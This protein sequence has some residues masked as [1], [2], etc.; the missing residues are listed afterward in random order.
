MSRQ[1]I[2]FNKNE[3]EDDSDLN[4]VER[5]LHVDSRGVLLVVQEQGHSD[6]HIF[7]TKQESH[8]GS[9]RWFD[10]QHHL[11]VH[12]A[13]VCQSPHRNAYPDKHPERAAQAMS[14]AR[15]PECHY[16]SKTTRQD[17]QE[18]GEKGSGGGSAERRRFE[19]VQGDNHR[20]KDQGLSGHP[21]SYF[22]VSA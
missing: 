14:A 3:K 19:Q 7:K 18:V 21:L 22:R 10:M 12:P 16:R 1:E 15:R 17:F 8:R 11:V 20:G 4:E 9:Q 6:E 13:E 2:E 5:G